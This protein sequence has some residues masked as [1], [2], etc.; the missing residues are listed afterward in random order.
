[1]K[2]RGYPPAK[3][4]R[5]R[6]TASTRSIGRP[7]STVPA[8]DF[9][10]AFGASAIALAEKDPT[11]CAVTR[12]D[13]TRHRAVRFARRFPDRYFELGIAEGTPPRCMPA[14]PWGLPILPFTPPF[15]GALTICLSENIGLMG[16]H[17]VLAV[18]RAGL[19]GRD[20][21][22]HQGSL[23]SRISALCEYDRICSG[24]LLRTGLH[25][26]HRRA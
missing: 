14:W 21:V 1:M 3:Q 20:G 11:V 5:R 13:G 18:D 19:V 15:S 2:E 6:T 7:A 23:I 16:L 26:I 4:T 17:V 12:G 22:T 25:A 24:E 9:S 8:N 10:A